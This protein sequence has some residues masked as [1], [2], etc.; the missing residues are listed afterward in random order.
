[1]SIIQV[2]DV[3]SSKLSQQID[4]CHLFRIINDMRICIIKLHKT[5]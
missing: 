3:D 5:S 4:C 1:M 2:F